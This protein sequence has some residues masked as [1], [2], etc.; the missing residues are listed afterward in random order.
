MARVQLPQLDERPDPL[1][2]E[3]RSI[4]PQC[5]ELVPARIVERDGKVLVRRSCETHGVFEGLVCSDL[6]WWR[7]LPKFDV[8]GLRPKVP[9]RGVERG[10]PEDCGLCAAHRQIAGT[11]AIEISNDC[12]AACPSCVADNQSTFFLSVEEVVTA[13]EA[14]LEQQDEI[15]VLALSGGEPT[16]HPQLLEIIAALHRPEV[17][18][19]VVNTNGLRIARDDAFL[20]RLAEFSNVYVS[21]HFDGDGA[22]SLR[23]IPRETQELALERLCRWG[24]PVVP[25]VL[26]AQ[27]VNDHELGALVT[28]LLTYSPQVRSVI[29]SMMTYAGRGGSA[30][31]G[32]PLDRL[33]IPGALDA[34]EASADGALKRRDFMPLPMPNPMCA[35]LGYFLTLDEEITPL[36]PLLPLERVIDYTKNSNFGKVDAELEALIRE[37]IDGVYANPDAHDDPQ[38]LLGKFRKLID[39]LFP[40]SGAIEHVARRQLAEQS[41]KTVYLMQFM[42][43]WSFDA[44]RLSKCSCQ[45]LLPEGEIIPSCG[46]YTL[47]RQ[48]D[49]RFSQPTLVELGQR[50]PSSEQG[51]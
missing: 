35:A 8:E 39:T 15:D 34:M 11:A 37:A 3:T 49:P 44:A 46:Y 12:N 40:E 30:F 18:R 24:V 28:R 50:T 2:Y 31:P 14:L 7:W 38:R 26:A 47:H 29:I 33:T 9:L 22:K 51:A 25:V 16:T 48:E 27:G 32:D 23:G 1:F 13:L 19:V 5:D 4:C 45:H 20:D 6:D 42:D 43:A 21:L 17:G 41:L 36:I 10:C